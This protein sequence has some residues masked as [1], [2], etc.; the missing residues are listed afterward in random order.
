MGTQALR[1]G[2]QRCKII[3]IRIVDVRHQTASRPHSLQPVPAPLKFPFSLLYINNSNLWPPTV[4]FTLRQHSRHI[5]YG[6]D[7]PIQ[8][9]QFQNPW[10]LASAMLKAPTYYFKKFI[11]E[12]A[13]TVGAGHV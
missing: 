5:F 4:E 13:T 9:D 3:E 2:L 11:G 10:S 1:K 8:I 7:V 12:R 6:P